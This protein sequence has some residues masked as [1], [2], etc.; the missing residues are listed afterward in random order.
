LKDQVA[1]P[2]L[3]DAFFELIAEAKF[4]FGEMG[5]KVFETDGG[6]V[7]ELVANFIQMSR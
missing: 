1:H 5:F 3:A 6:Q 7:F 2:V 4:I